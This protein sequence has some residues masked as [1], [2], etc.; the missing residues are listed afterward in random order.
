MKDW[1]EILKLYQRDNLNLAEGAS[2]LGRTVTYEI[3]ALKRLS[4][5][6]EQR[7]A[8]C[9]KQEATCKKQAQDYRDKFIHSCTQLGLHFENFHPKKCSEGKPPTVN[10]IGF[11]LVNQMSHKLPEIF[12]TISRMSKG[13]QP[14]IEF[15]RKFLKV[16]V[17]LTEGQLENCCSLL[18][19]II[20]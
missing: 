6:L 7:Q 16:T 10:S 13:V 20:G 9:L 11:Q 8:E 18:S 3:P 19:T 14:A 15:Y 12:A 5:K 4:T 1:Q 17:G 2:I